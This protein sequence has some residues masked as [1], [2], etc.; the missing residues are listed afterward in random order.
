[1]QQPAVAQTNNSNTKENDNCPKIYTGIRETL[2][3]MV[4]E[5]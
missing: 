2:Q 4:V 1:M 5:N 3:K